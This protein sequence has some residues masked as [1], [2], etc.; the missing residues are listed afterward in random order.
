MILVADESIDRQ[1]VDQLRNCGYEVMWVA[2]MEPGITDAAVLDMANS[3]DALL[4]TADKDFGEIVFRQ[5]RV[6]KGVILI[7][8][9]G[10]PQE[11]KGQ[12]VFTA[13]QKYLLEMC[14]SYTVITP[15]RIRIRKMTPQA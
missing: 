1:I 3:R 8:L 9:A 11:K 13:L 5:R 6:S 4:I 10:L 2:E 15:S 14:N 7:R 12:L